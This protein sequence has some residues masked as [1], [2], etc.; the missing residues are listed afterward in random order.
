MGRRRK[1]GSIIAMVFILL[2]AAAVFVHIR[3]ST[4]HI[5]ETDYV[6]RAYAIL[7]DT[8]NTVYSDVAEVSLVKLK[9]EKC[10]TPPD[11]RGKIN[12]HLIFLNGGYAVKVEIHTDLDGLL[13]PIT[14]YFNPFTRQWIGMAPRY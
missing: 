1:V 12:R 3:V 9:K 14:L 11:I 10:I 4:V 7:S 5:D 2:V 8:W 6:K 13:G